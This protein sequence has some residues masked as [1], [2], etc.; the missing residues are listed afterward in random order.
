MIRNDYVLFFIVV[1]I[2]FFVVV[3]RLRAPKSPDDHA[4][5]GNHQFSY[6]FMP[7]SGSYFY[8]F[9]FVVVF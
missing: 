7:F 5:M 2:V 3:N 4:D 8:F 9:C 6:A 1:V